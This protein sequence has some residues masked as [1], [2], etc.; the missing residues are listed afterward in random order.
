[1]KKII[2]NKLKGILWVLGALAALFIIAA[3]HAYRSGEAFLS[4]VVILLCIALCFVCIYHAFTKF[5]S[6]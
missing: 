2:S 3:A 4:G 5:R 6:V 1:M